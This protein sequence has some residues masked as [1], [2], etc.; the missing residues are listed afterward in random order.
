MRGRAAAWQLGTCGEVPLAQLT[1][2]AV[3]AATTIITADTYIVF[4]TWQTL[5][6]CFA[7]QQPILQ[8]RKLRH[9]VGKVLSNVIWVVSCR[10][11]IQTLS[12]S[13]VSCLRP[14]GVP[15][16][17]P[18]WLFSQALKAL[19]PPRSSRNLK[20]GPFLGRGRKKRPTCGILLCARLCCSLGELMCSSW[21][22]PEPFLLVLLLTWSTTD[23]VQEADCVPS[24][25][26]GSMRGTPPP[27]APQQGETMW[28]GRQGGA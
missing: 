17:G 15:A 13:R 26:L 16:Q 21:R 20:R 22:D 25:V 7:S 9:R 1:R 10:A 2:A 4:I 6:Q 5:F 14:A 27:G 23:C 18:S 12:G 3:S 28:P 11:R 19:P 8:M 24:P